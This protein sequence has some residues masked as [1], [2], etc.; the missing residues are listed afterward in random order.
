MPAYLQSEL[1]VLART[2]HHWVILLRRP[3]LVLALALLVLLIAAVVDPWPMAAVFLVV[4]GTFAFVRW[5]TWQ[6]EWVILTSRRIIRVRGVPETTSAE[7]SLRLDRISGAVLEQTVLGK[8]LGFGTIE[9]EAPGQHPDVR[10]L[11]NIARPH[12]F[13]LQTRKVVF[14]NDLDLDPDYLP[15]NNSTAPLP[16]T[17]PYGDW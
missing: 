15:Q 3:H 14:G 10:R 4:F 2:R 5:Q 7:A 12:E 9:L 6:A 1:P 13:Y 17:P 16:R 8:L 11:V